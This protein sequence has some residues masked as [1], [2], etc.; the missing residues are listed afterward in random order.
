MKRILLLISI[1]FIFS[2]ALIPVEIKVR[3]VRIILVLPPASLPRLA[4]FAE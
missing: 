3:N 1:L 2:F 4:P